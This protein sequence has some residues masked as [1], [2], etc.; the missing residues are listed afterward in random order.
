VSIAILLLVVV[1]LTAFYAPSVVL[2]QQSD[3]ST[4]ISS[5][6]RSLIQCY[7]AARAA[8]AASANISKLTL[9][10]NNA[11]L[12]LSRAELAYSNGD[13]GAAQSLAFQS[14]NILV[15]FVSDANS[16]HNSAA[17]NRTFS[18]LTNVVGSILGT[19][20]LLTAS[21]VVWSKLKK[22]KQWSAKE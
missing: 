6:E 9:R 11:S 16:L 18:F 14:Q 1:S 17:Q 3:I 5:V 2:A 4:T 12:L 15:G 22:R 10:L 13:F 20:L 8:E 21:F 7:D 19:I